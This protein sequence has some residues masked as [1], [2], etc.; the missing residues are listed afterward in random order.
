M[1]EAFYNQIVTSDQG[2]E[3]A[4]KTL[5][6]T[7]VEGVTHMQ[8]ASGEIPRNVLHKDLIPEVSYDEA[9]QAIAKDV[10]AFMFGLYDDN[11]A[12]LQTRVE[13]TGKLV[14]PIVD[15]LLLE[16]YHQPKPPA[17]EQ[18]DEYGG[19]EFGTCPQKLRSS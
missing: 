18:V 11:W 13:E 6:V 2:K 17:I 8:F 9:H 19:L 7:V 3:T 15:A 10:A 14:E 12:D 4:M 5:P 1:A 16:G